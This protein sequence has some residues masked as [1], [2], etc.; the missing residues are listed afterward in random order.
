MFIAWVDQK[1]S[2]I[3]DKIYKIKNKIKL[4]NKTDFFSKLEDR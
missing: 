2:K 1:D 3:G 4:K